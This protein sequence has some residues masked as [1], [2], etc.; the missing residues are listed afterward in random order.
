MLDRNS[1]SIRTSSAFRRHY[2]GPEPR[3]QPTLLAGEAPREWPRYQVSIPKNDVVQ[4]RGSAVIS[5][6]K[7]SN[8]VGPILTPYRGSNQRDGQGDKRLH[9]YCRC[10][11]HETN[12]Q[13]RKVAS[14]E[15]TGLVTKAGKSGRAGIRTEPRRL[16]RNPSLGLMGTAKAWSRG[17]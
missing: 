7:G 3:K 11:K 15:S 13:R 14:P 5:D 4:V 6:S 8:K 2:D 1:S 10:L 16:V 9:G 12:G 17:F